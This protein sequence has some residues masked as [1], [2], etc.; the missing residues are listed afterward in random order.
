MIVRARP[1]KNPVPPYINTSND[2]THY[3][4]L[5]FTPDALLTYNVKNGALRLHGKMSTITPNI[6]SLSNNSTVTI[7]GLLYSG[8]PW[9]KSALDKNISLTYSLNLPWL[10]MDLTADARK[11]DD[12]FSTYYQWQTIDG[13]RVIVGRDENC[14]YLLNYGFS[15]SLAL[16]PFSND[17]LSIELESGYRWQKEK[18]EIIG[19]HHHHYMPLAWTVDMRK[20]CWGAEYYQCIP[21][22]MLSGSFINSAENTQNLMVYYQ[23]EQLM[24]GLVCIFPFAA[25][26]Y[27]SSI[28]D[29]D[30]L[31]K[32]GWNRVTSQKRTFCITLSYNL[33]SG[34]QNNDEKKLNNKDNDKGFF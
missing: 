14:D 2:D 5:Y 22:K 15:G 21:H 13:N 20:G 28:L 19:T 33:F 25:A 34:K 6:A 31:D 27:N 12:D 9:L 18:S 23:K 30:V 32:H 29:N 7:P 26:K 3:H 4:K 17:L 24:V 8:N 1:Q 16:R 10:N 11:I